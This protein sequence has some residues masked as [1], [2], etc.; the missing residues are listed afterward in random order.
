ME[1]GQIPLSEIGRHIAHV[2]PLF[3]ILVGAAALIGIGELVLLVIAVRHRP[4][5]R[6]SA[7][8][9]IAAVVGPVLMAA[10]IAASIHIGHETLLRGIAS[11]KPG[12][13]VAIVV[14]GLEGFMNAQALGPF[15]LG[16]VLGLA[17]IA[18][19]L[20]ASAALGRRPRALAAASVVFVGAGMAPLLYG[21]LS[22]STQTI[23][24]LA[25]VAGIDVAMK[26]LMITK[27]LEETRALL[28]RWALVGACG[29]GVALIVGIVGAVRDGVRPEGHRVSWW[30]PAICLVVA[31]GLFLA[32]EPLRAENTTP[33]PPSAG[34]ALTNNVV[35]TPDVEGPDQV[36]PAEVVTI[37]GDRTL[38][39]GVPRNSVELRDM[40]VVMRNNYNLLH[41]DE[42]SDEDLV[43][44]CAPGTR[45]EHLIEV[46]QWAK[47]TE[48]R[49][50]A[51]AFGKRTT[52]E[53]PVM[54]TLPRWQWTAAKAL[55]PGAGPESPTPIVTLT[56]DDYP[57]C[58]G[59]ARAVAAIR[60]SGKIAGLA[61]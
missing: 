46:L 43:I 31:A 24:V 5:N 51:F 44:V 52:I 42:S 22:Y 47:V 36:P 9:A 8:Y 50:P 2:I 35:A 25:T 32:A 39:N 15:L 27:G 40:L 20:H 4:G 16:P 57:S 38:G 58:D 29:L 33:W 61:F 34:A 18:A 30:S 56:V 28:D 1:R 49:R 59:V 17:A 7:W 13:N 37:I 12:E 6:P 41:P 10:L 45:T 26:Q 11:S 14:A 55:I 53:R 60:R 3:W 19:S 48:Y 23:K 21:V 54:G